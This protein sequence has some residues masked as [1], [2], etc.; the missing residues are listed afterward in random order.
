[1]LELVEAAGGFFFEISNDPQ[2]AEMRRVADM[3]AASITASF[4][5]ATATRP[6]PAPT[7]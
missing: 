6:A 5:R 1:M 7:A 2:V 4:S 3:V